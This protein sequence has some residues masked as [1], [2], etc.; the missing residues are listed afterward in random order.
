MLLELFGIL[1]GQSLRRLDKSQQL[2]RE[3]FIFH[4]NE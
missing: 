2:E 3:F 4:S 1:P